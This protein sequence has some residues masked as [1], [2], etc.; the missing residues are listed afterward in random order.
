MMV[1]GYE[2]FAV[3]GMIVY[4][5]ICVINEHLRSFTARLY[6]PFMHVF[7]VQMYIKL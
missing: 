2:V 4:V 1:L 5:V 6:V 3:T 7:N